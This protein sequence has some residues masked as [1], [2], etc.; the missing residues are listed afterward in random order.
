MLKEEDVS[1]TSNFLSI[2][3]STPPSQAVV[4]FA[5][6]FFN[7]LWNEKILNRTL[8]KSLQHS[9]LELKIKRNYPK[10]PIFYKSYEQHVKEIYCTVPAP[11]TECI[12]FI[13]SSL[14]NLHKEGIYRKSG[15]NDVINGMVDLFDK[16]DYDFLSRVAA[17]EKIDT[18]K[19]LGPKC[20]NIEVYDVCDCLKR[21]LRFLPEYLISEELEKQLM[22]HRHF[23]LENIKAVFKN[24]TKT[25][26]NATVRA[27]LAQIFRHL[28][29]V[30]NYRTYNSMEPFNLSLM[31]AFI[32][33]N[34]VKNSGRPQNSRQGELIIFMINYANEIFDEKDKENFNAE[35]TKGFNDLVGKDMKELKNVKDTY[36]ESLF[37]SEIRSK[38][39]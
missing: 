2:S 33:F 26:K 16:G 38:E 4:D 3:H 30:T 21:Y 31:F 18:Q 19:L 22:K 15:S 29:L 27:S 24:L 37:W 39:K 34:S 17:N 35:D 36:N 32:L 1:R 5:R 6:K 13:Q 20:T 25:P 11:I 14:D 9:I 23:S 10:N 12:A 7:H 8:I 28:K